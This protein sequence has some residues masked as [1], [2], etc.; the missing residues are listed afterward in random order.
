VPPQDR[1]H[2]EEL[3]LKREVGRQLG[4]WRLIASRSNDNAK[5][6]NEGVS[7]YLEKRGLSI[8]QKKP[9]RSL[10]FCNSRQILHRLLLHSLTHRLPPDLPSEVACCDLLRSVLHEVLQQSNI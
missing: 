7:M 3:Y 4:R 8:V 2:R 5:E 10:R 9:Q 6:G 1:N